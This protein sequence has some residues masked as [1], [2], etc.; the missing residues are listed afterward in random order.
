MLLKR[1]NS[2]VKMAV[3]L[4]CLRALFIVLSICYVLVGL[5]GSILTGVFIW[6]FS[7]TSEIKDLFTLAEEKTVFNQVI[8]ALIVICVAFGV[9]MI[10][11]FIGCCAMG[12][13]HHNQCCQDLLA[14][15]ALIITLLFTAAVILLAVYRNKL[16]S[17]VKKSFE[18]NMQAYSNIGGPTVIGDVA[19]GA[20]NSYVDG[21]QRGHSCCGSYGYKSWQSLGTPW[22]A[23][24]PGRLAP[25]SCCVQSNVPDCN[26]DPNAL[27]QGGCSA[28]LGSISSEVYTIFY[29][30]GAVIAVASLIEMLTACYMARTSQKQD[31]K[32]CCC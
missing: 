22:V 1:R 32:G 10:A 15:F 27:H 16:E 2:R 19:E 14:V 29:I 24:N 30:V 31:G 25:L 9:M 17:G 5:V 8:I 6:I 7:S 3:A 13:R 23:A 21:V 18:I 4:A 28:V 11:G 12:R 26:K 20:V